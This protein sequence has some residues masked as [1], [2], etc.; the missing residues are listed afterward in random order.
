MYRMN[1]FLF[2]VC[3]AL[4]AFSVSAQSF[5]IVPLGVKGGID[6][7]NLSAY[8]V[9]AKGTDNYICLDAGTLHYGIEKAVSNKVFTVSAEQVLRQYI[10]GYFIS[11]AHLD[12]ISGLIINSPDDTAKTIYALASCI[13]TIKTHYFTW[14][15]WA[16]FTDDGTA[17]LLKK[18]HYQVL[19][20]D[21]MLAIKN[22]EMTVKAFPLAHSN[23]TSTAFLVGGNDAYLL[24]LGDTGADE[25]EKSQNLHNLWQAVAPLIKSK[26][27]KGIMIETSF[28]DEQ[29][30]KTL[31]GHLTPRWLMREMDNLA[32]L[33]GA[34]ALRGFNLIVTHVKPPQVSINKI[35]VQLKAENKLGFNLIFP[36]QGKAIEL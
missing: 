12:H 25:L 29:P 19:T 17:P 3:S 23:L 4:T 21:S 10:K 18:Y 36:E 1:A 7:S 9:A 26:K 11:H 32:A 2:I 8:M 34:E 31:F 24:Y 20:P 27:L 15:S 22:T 6:E 35:K 33:T 5:K 16:N 13:E 14:D 30:D 28:P